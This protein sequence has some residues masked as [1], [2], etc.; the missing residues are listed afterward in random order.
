MDRT[1]SG[2]AEADLKKSFAGNNSRNVLQSSG[3]STNV[4]GN[5]KPV[6]FSELPFFRCFAI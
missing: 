2:R 5:V 1:S 6:M 3:S 4:S